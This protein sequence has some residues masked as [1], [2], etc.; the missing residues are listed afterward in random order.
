MKRFEFYIT[1]LPLLAAALLHTDLSAAE[2]SMKL[3]DA[4]F[5]GGGTATADM[6]NGQFMNLLSETGR[7]DVAVIASVANA[8]MYPGRL[9]QIYEIGEA[10]LALTSVP[11]RSQALVLPAF[12]MTDGTTVADPLAVIEWNPSSGPADMLDDGSVKTGAVYQD[13]PVTLEGRLSGIG[14]VLGL[15]VQETIPDNFGI[16]GRDGIDDPWQV[17]YFGQDNPLAAPLLDPDGDGQNN[18]F[19]FTAG[20][21]PTNPLSRFLLS[22]APVPDQPGQ[23]NVIFG[24]MVSGRTYVVKT[25]PDLSPSSWNTLPGGSVTDNGSQRTVTDTSASESRKF[26]RVEIMK[27]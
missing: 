19:E 27:P 6:K 18:A 3:L 2:P 23:K 10:S 1:R 24:P 8:V 15:L 22:I 17:Q 14:F 7:G 12:I 21:I 16:Y 26:Y 4:G 25:S 13:T 11:E 5:A 20:L 9:G